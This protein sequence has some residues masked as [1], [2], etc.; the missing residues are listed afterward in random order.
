MQR[1][2]LNYPRLGHKPFHLDQFVDGLQIRIFFREIAKGWLH[3]EAGEQIRASSVEISEQRVIATHIVIVDRL[4]KQ[5]AR[6][7]KEHFFRIGGSSQF[8]KAEAGVQKPGSAMRRNAA[9][10]AANDQGTAPTPT[11]HE[12]VQAQLQDLGT[13]LERRVDGV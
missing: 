1:L 3:F 5:S 13:P 12:M 7:A 2:R 10:L 6:A 8:V 4:C 11:L 9:E